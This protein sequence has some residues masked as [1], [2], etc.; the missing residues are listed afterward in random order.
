MKKLIVGNWK[1]NPSTLEEA[2]NIGARLK[3]VAVNLTNTSIVV[4][5]PYSFVLGI[6]PRTTTHNFSVGA[7]SASYEGENG[8]YTGEVSAIML[9]DIGV[10]YVIVGHSEQRKKGDTDIIVSKRLFNVL[11]TGMQAVLC[12]GENTRDE[13]GVYMEELKN[14]IKNS[15][16]DIPKKYASKIIIAYE[17]VW[18]IG[19]KDAMAPEQI[20]E[21]SLFVRKVFADIFGPENGLK[22]RV[23]YGGAVN[24]RNASDIMN[25]GKVDGLLVGRESV[26]TPGFIE[27]IK[28]IDSL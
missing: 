1:M 4:C 15:L 5:P 2:R 25:V 14:Q 22:V 9:A 16:T 23:L 18:A 12:V 8:P 20:Y 28:S 21:T 26:N 3:R 11:N 27:L 19:A 6:I 13:A 7:Q 10:E 24:F 17:P